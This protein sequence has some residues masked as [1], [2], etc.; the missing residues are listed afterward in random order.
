MPFFAY[1]ASA[2]QKG[3][4]SLRAFE[5]WK[6]DSLLCGNDLSADSSGFLLF[7]SGCEAKCVVYLNRYMYKNDTLILEPYDY[8]LESF[9]A[10]VTKVLG[11]GNLQKI[12]FLGAG[13][14]TVKDNYDSASM[15][16]LLG[17]L[18][19]K[20]VTFNDGLQIP[21]GRYRAIEIWQLSQLFGVPAIFW[22]ESE[23][24]YTITLNVPSDIFKYII[25]GSGTLHNKYLVMQKGKVYF[26]EE[27][28]KLKIEELNGEHV[29]Y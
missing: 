25:K 20:W 5:Y 28:H 29:K 24:D 13:G 12:T 23:F 17:G 9:F 19:T 1:T 26:P 11:N 10:E 6:G 7:T 4:K 15:V 22:L 16:K 2:Q 27:G 3:F 18:T 14:D 8:L 21:R